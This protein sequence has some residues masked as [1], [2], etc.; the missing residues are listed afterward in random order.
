MSTR[1]V[2]EVFYA[3]SDRHRRTIASTNFMLSPAVCTS[4]LV[5]KD[6]KKQQVSKQAD[7]VAA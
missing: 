4:H 2:G 5:N 3:A 1:R 6:G 7:G